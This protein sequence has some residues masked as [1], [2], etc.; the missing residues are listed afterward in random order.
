MWMNLIEETGNA[1]WNWWGGWTEAGGTCQVYSETNREKNQL[2]GPHPNGGEMSCLGSFPL[3][4]P[5]LC[6]MLLVIWD[7]HTLKQQVLGLDQTTSF[8]FYVT[9]KLW[10]HSCTATHTHA[11]TKVFSMCIFVEPCVTQSVLGPLE[12]E[13]YTVVSCHV[14]ASN[15]SWAL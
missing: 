8:Y 13:L 6:L 3:G 12:V 5:T 11:R 14:G 10:R 1:A 2:P 7:L 15:Q 4:S 9:L